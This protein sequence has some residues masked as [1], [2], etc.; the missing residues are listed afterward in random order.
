MKICYS[1]PMRGK[2][3]P[4]AGKT[5]GTTKTNPQITVSFPAK[6]AMTLYKNKPE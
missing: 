3:G 4:F 1:Q 6:I 2:G 5:A